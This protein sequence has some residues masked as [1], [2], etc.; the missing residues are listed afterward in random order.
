MAGMMKYIKFETELSDDV[1]FLKNVKY[2]K[3]SRLLRHLA[4]YFAP[5]NIN[6]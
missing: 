3:V 6:V 4:L 5:R 1:L 2:L